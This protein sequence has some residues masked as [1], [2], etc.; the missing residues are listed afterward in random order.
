MLV[1]QWTSSTA[2]GTIGDFAVIAGPATPATSGKYWV[3]S[4]VPT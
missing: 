2:S 4:S 3:K 1:K